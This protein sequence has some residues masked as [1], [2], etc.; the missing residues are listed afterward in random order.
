MRVLVVD[1]EVDFLETMV[2]RLKRRRLDAAG[3][4]SGKAALDLLETQPF[5]VVIL[6]IRM[7]GMDG[8]EVLKLIKRRHP[9]IEVILLTGHASIESGMQG[10][11]IG[12]FDYVMK[13]ANFD[14]LLEKAQQAYERKLLHGKQIE[15]RL[16]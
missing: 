7:P 16:R 2:N 14:Q 5:D 12:A 13:P 11:Q 3:V 15:Q 8:L 10:M 9:L 1:D 6:D 4:E